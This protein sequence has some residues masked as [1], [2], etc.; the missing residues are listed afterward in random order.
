MCVVA[1]DK[2]LAWR[3]P[4]DFEFFV[5]YL[6]PD[7]DAP[8][9]GSSRTGSVDDL[10][11]PA[12]VTVTARARTTVLRAAIVDGRSTMSGVTARWHAGLAHVA[13][14]SPDGTPDTLRLAVAEATLYRRTGPPPEWLLVDLGNAADDA[15]QTHTAVEA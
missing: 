4:A 3:S 9:A 1:D 15:G 5:R 14:L 8:R 11:L 12:P 10:R 13:A 7:P 6:A 2:T